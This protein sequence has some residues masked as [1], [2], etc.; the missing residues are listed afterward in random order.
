[1]TTT[2][3]LP[4]EEFARVFNT[5]LGMILVVGEANVARTIRELEA[6]DETVYTVGKL[7]ERT[8]EEGCV[9]RNM[10]GWS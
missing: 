7:I 9:L 8:E 2:G 10:N 5:G 3:N 1:M 4:H 6:A